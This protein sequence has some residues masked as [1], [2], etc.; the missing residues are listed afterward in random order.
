MSDNKKIWHIWSNQRLEQFIKTIQLG[1]HVIMLCPEEYELYIPNFS[2]KELVDAGALKIDIVFGTYDI[3]Y[4]RKNTDID[5]FNNVH[6]HLWHNFF[7]YFAVCRQCI[8]GRPKCAVDKLF[9]TLNH[10]PHDHRIMLM[11]MFEKYNLLNNNYYSWLN[12]PTE[13]TYKPKYFKYKIKELDDYL[14]EPSTGKLPTEYYK[15]AIVIANESNVKVPFITEKTF[16]AIFAQKPVIIYG[17]KGINA[18]LEE[19]GFKLPRHIIDYSFDN[20]VDDLIRAEKI[21]RELQ[22]LST[23]SIDK[24][25]KETA[26]T[27]EYNINHAFNIIKTSTDIPDIIKHTSCRYHDML[28]DSTLCAQRLAENIKNATNNKS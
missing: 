25:V 24:I 7:L 16:N 11:D 8:V 6:L 12:L 1:D 13:T 3:N 26:S 19:L 2:F 27:A 4:I 18:Q 17:C 28:L 14:T 15:S 20:E 9:I 22:R 23:I 10:R 5:N 21:A